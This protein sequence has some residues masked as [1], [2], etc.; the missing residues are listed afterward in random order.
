MGEEDRPHDGPKCR[1][2]R[3]GVGKDQRGLC[4]AGVRA[5]PGP[6]VPRTPRMPGP[7]PLLQAPHRPAPRRPPRHWPVRAG[8][9]P[10]STRGFIDPDTRIPM[11][12]LPPVP[13]C[14]RLVS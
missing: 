8:G 3:R 7:R 12:D 9:T 2:R 1:R 5:I 6:D 13:H 11:S 10:G 4:G 14:S